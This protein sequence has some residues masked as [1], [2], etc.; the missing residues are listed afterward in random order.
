ML[1]E[2]F[3]GVQAVFF[4]LDNTLIDRDGAFRRALPEWL[5]KNVGGLR[6]SEYDTHIQQILTRDES[7]QTDRLQFCNWIR[8]T[9]SLGH[10]QPGNILAD[11]S[12]SIAKKIVRDNE[13]IRLLQLLKENFLI[14]L[15]TNGSGVAQRI[16]LQQAGLDKVFDHNTVYIEGET[17]FAKPHPTAFTLP[18]K[19]H[20][21]PAEKFLFIGDHPVNDMEGASQNG[22]RT[23]WIRNSQ[24]SFPA[25]AVDL[26]LKN[27][28]ELV[29]C[30]D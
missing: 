21:I 24:S 26:T 18:V 28:H 13:V 11:L 2:I 1:P 9:Y 5:N 29:P 12:V 3:N 14:G 27:V 17:G 20:H 6:E 4:D 8:S 19:D 16:K 23:C 25:T 7:G 10:V 15:I 30:H 22:M